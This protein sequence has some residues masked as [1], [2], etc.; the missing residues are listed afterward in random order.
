MEAFKLHVDHVFLNEFSE[1]LDTIPDFSYMDKQ[2]MIGMAKATLENSSRKGIGPWMALQTFRQ[3]LTETETPEHLTQISQIAAMDYAKF[4]SYEIHD[5]L[6]GIDND[7]S[8]RDSP[9]MWIRYGEKDAI[10]FGNILSSFSHHLLLSEKTHKDPDVRLRLLDTLLKTD[11]KVL[12][13]Q[14]MDTPME[15][16]MVV[17]TTLKTHAL[18]TANF[19]SFIA[20]CG[21]IIAGADNQTI[22]KMGELG[23]KIGHCNQIVNDSLPEDIIGDCESN[24]PNIVGAI[25]VDNARKLFDSYRTQAQFILNNIEDRS[26]LQGF[27]DNITKNFQQKMLKTSAYFS[28]DAGGRSRL[29]R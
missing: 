18:K 28:Q 17:P 10:L 23:K 14:T 9:S 29:G 22:T 12:Y 3:C 6:P 2:K 8:R 27:L 11:I 7:H 26:Y 25:G 13:G 21:A 19:A 15:E 20:K 4:T 24:K 1:F 5:D 16:S